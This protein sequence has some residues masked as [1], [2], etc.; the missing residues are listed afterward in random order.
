MLTVW[1]WIMNL[2]KFA[3]PAFAWRDWGNCDKFLSGRVVVAEIW[4]EHF[5]VVVRSVTAESLCCIVILKTLRIRLVHRKLLRY[6]RDVFTLVK[7]LEAWNWTM[8]IYWSVPYSCT[9]YVIRNLMQ[10]DETKFI[11]RYVRVQGNIDLLWGVIKQC[12][13]W[14]CLIVSSAWLRTRSVVNICFRFFFI[15]IISGGKEST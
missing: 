15:I 10:M 5:P 2:R 13:E 7:N 6:G 4:T 14:A 1:S 12:R 11:V 8:S 3:I 9:K